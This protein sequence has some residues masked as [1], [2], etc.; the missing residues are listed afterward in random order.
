MN[1]LAL[2]VGSSS[3]KYKFYNK[4][5]I[6]GKIERV[7]DFRKGVKEIVNKLENIDVVGH[8]VVHAGF[9]N[10][11]E[12][13]NENVIK[14][15]EKFS[16]LA[17]LHNV[18]E[19]E[20]IKALKKYKQV[21]V[22]D[23]VFYRDL[24]EKVFLYPIPYKYYK[25][26]GIRRLG[27]HGLAHQYVASKF[28]NKKIISC[29][30]G[31]GCSITAIKNNKAVDTSMGFTPVEGI[32]MGTRSGDVDAGIIDFLIK[33][34]ININKLI[35]EESGFKGITGKE[36]YRDIK[37]SN[38]KLDKLAREMF[39]Y[40]IRKYIGA[41]NAVLDKADIISFSGAIGENVASLRKRVTKGFKAK[42]KVVKVDE[43]EIIIKEVRKLIK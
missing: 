21:A 19:V 6:S 24:S 1:I 15:I 11:H 16:E 5:I 26:Y 8:R 37:N 22:Y 34:K 28:K 17:P 43:E 14:K 12:I 4:K 9:V 18:N 40:R 7:K 41:Y 27:F 2:N 31:A 36:D 23:S 39:E 29:H 38:K 25:K 42:I 3:I 10:K 20:A 35:N 13:I 32:M 30:L 33:K